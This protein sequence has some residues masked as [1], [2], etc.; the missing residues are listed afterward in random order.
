MPESQALVLNASGQLCGIGETGEIVLRTPYRTLGYM[1]LP[2]ENQ[3]RFRPNPFRNDEN[4]LVYFTGDRGRYRVDGLL[5]IAGRVDDQVKIRGVLVEPGEVTAALARHEAVRECVV[6][7][8]DDD[9]RRHQLVGY[10]VTA[11]N[12]RLNA[13]DL[14]AYLSEQLPQAFVPSAFVFLNALPVLPNGKVDRRALPAPQ[15]DMAAQ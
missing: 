2:E 1:N 3:R 6:V 9:Q 4:D 14:R 8:R 10:V 13:S 12:K 11:K 5:E 7:A 15:Y